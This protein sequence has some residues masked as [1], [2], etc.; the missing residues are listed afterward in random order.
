MP[1]QSG[2]TSTAEMQLSNRPDRVIMLVPGLNPGRARYIAN[3]AV[4]EA[5]RKMP[6]MTGDSARRIQP[7]YGK[8][9]FGIYFPDSVV[10][11]QDHGIRPFTMNNLQGKTI[12]MWIDDPTGA[13]KAKNPK[14][15][16]RTTASGKNQILI[17]RKVANKGTQTLK[18]K[19]DPKTGLK[20][21]V[22]K[23]GSY[24]GAPGR[25]GTRESGR[26]STTPGRVAGAVARNNVGV[27]WRH[28]GLAPRL[29]LN[30][31]L[32]LAAQW[33]NI[34]PIR[35]YIADRTSNLD[36]RHLG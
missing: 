15:K 6:K 23:P 5:R 8:G 28:P 14:A 24:P 16:T 1:M 7:I 4:R 25:I 33:N 32:T 36:L 31:A 29:F 19:T 20:T 17:F 30:N 11:F 12:P 18:Y 21:L 26:P 10:W 2:L 9:F 34:L 22:S 13:E 35:V 3:Q 27:K